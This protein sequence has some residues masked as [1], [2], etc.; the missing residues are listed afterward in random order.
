M[1]Q[2]TSSVFLFLSILLFLAIY[3]YTETSLINKDGYFNYHISD[4]MGYLFFWSFTLLILSL[5]AFKLDI[6]KYKIWLII[7]LVVSTISIFLASVTGD[8]GGAIVSF[9]GEDLTWFFAG[10]YSFVCIVYFIVQF[11]KNK[12]Q[13]TLV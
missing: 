8:G 13:S 2:R 10:L 1:K 3:T 6:N 11:L 7:S 9:G 12:K 5:L 4:F